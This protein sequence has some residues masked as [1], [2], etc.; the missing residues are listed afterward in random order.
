MN[1]NPSIEVENIGHLGLVAAITKKYN[2]IFTVAN[3]TLHVIYHPVTSLTDE[4]VF[5]TFSA[6]DIV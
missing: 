1:E 6:V 4:S 2:F 5:S 3:F